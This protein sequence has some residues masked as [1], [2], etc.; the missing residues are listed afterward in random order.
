MDIKISNPDESFLAE[1]DLYFYGDNFWQAPLYK[2][3]ENLNVEQALWRPAEDKHCIWQL[4]R[5]LN[6]WKYWAL[7]YAKEA[8]LKGL[9]LTLE[10]GLCLEA[11]LYCLLQTTEDRTE[12]IRAFLE[13]RPPQFKDR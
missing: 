1:S 11:D 2:Q 6:Y 9:D 4:V 8:I 10:Q 12:G 5:H 7:K 3:V 13:K